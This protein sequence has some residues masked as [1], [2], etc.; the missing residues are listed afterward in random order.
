MSKYYSTHRKDLLQP[1]HSYFTKQTKEAFSPFFSLAAE[2]SDVIMQIT[3]TQNFVDCDKGLILFFSCYLSL[4][5]LCIHVPFAELK[6]SALSLTVVSS[7]FNRAT[8][9]VQTVQRQGHNVRLLHLT[10]WADSSDMHS[11]DTCPPPLLRNL[12]EV[13]SHNNGQL[14]NC[15]C[16]WNSPGLRMRKRDFFSFLKKLLIHSFNASAKHIYRFRHM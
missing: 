12:F 1:S 13:V 16:M 8:G 5:H 10:T 3:H 14:N 11:C 2:S 7:P 9:K 4:V 6:I 15:S